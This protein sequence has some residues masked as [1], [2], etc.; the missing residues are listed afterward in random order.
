MKKKL[1][2]ALG[3]TGII[4]LS[5]SIG[6]YAASPIKLFINGKAIT[7]DVQIVKGSSYVPLK[8]VS[9]SL[10]ADVKWD[11]VARTITITSGTPTPT[12]V[13]ANPAKSF[14]VNVNVESGPVKLNISK[15]TFDPAYKKDTYSTAINAVILDVTA[16]N[17]SSDSLMWY[18]TQSPVVF[19]TKEQV[20]TAI[21]NSD[22]IDGDFLGKVIKKG[23]MVYEVKGD[24]SEI[25]SAVISIAGPL[26]KKTYDSLGEAKTAEILLQ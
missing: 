19:N 18:Y 9:E 8:V 11:G 22:S 7:A 10:G 20:D 25:N 23:K 2:I 26:D 4:A 21:F 1:F 5:V 6:V 17:T 12:P 15:I 24:L 14:P 13:P 3:L 16:E